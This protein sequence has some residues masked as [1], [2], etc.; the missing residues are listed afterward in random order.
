[1]NAVAISFFVNFPSTGK[2][3][4]LRYFCWGAVETTD[5]LTRTDIM[6]YLFFFCVCVHSLC[7][8]IAIDVK[9]GRLDIQKLKKI[10]IF[11]LFNQ[12][13]IS[14]KK[15]GGAVDERIWY[16]RSSGPVRY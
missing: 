13:V 10:N 11:I 1:M 3:I 7:I 14:Q 5:W 15:G 12:E 16:H 2:E 4:I 6:G 8:S 9:F